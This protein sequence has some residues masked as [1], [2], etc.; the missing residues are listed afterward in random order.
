MSVFGENK[1][2]IS[3]ELYERLDDEVCDM[4]EVC[5]MEVFAEHFGEVLKDYV[6]VAKAYIVED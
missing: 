1:R 2:N 4:S 5:N 6:L 3:D